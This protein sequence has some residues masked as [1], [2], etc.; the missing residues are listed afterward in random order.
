M[1]ITEGN[2]AEPAVTRSAV[3]TQLSTTLKAELIKNTQR[4]RE[5]IQFMQE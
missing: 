1:T 5:W 4:L 2:N 3:N